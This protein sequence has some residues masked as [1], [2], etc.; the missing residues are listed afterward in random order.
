MTSHRTLII[1]AH[2]NLADSRANAARLT[3]IGNLES[4]TVHDL[5]RAYP[6][7]SID[8]AHEQQLLREHDT[9]IL[10][11][12]LCW[13]SVTP[14]VKA[15]FDA[16]LTY[17]FAFTLDGSAS[18]LHGKKAWLAVS[19]GSTL[20]TYTAEGVARR[21]L[22]EYLA[23]VRQTLEFCQFDYQGVHAVYG[24]MLNPSDEHLLLDAKEYGM[25]VA[26]SGAPF[27]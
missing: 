3:E 26:T 20:D 18:Q 9:V 25:L 17:G 12:P 14:L 22:E 27:A 19:V 11:F 6:E 2:P 8:V 4:V 16:V 24:M 7:F 10:Q 23:P 21:S 1:V 15:W 5:Y 13:Y